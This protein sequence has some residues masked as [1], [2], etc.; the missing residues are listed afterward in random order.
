MKKFSLA[1]LAMA[2]ALAIA[3]AAMADM[4]TY[5]TSGTFSESGTAIGTWGS[6]TFTFDGV[7]STTIGP[8]P[9]GASLGNMI[10]SGS[11]T[12]SG[13]FTVTIDQTDP[14]VGSG[15]FTTGALSG[16]VTNS[17]NGVLLDFTTTSLTLGDETYTLQQ[18]AGGYILVPPNDEGGDTSLQMEVTST[19]EPSSLLLLGTGLL[20]LAFVAFR[21]A[22]STGMALN[23]LSM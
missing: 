17:S 4:V 21:K 19:P 6:L 9:T 23:T 8:T 14:S 3:P 22:K 2:T 1:L 11:G 12:P 15:T 10:V 20:G 7:A 5:S 18:P 13:T 16:T